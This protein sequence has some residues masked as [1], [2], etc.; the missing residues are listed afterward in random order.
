MYF[1]N[2]T[3]IYEG[4]KVENLFTIIQ[5]HLSKSFQS[6]Q[7]QSFIINLVFSSNPKTKR[8]VST[9]STKSK[10][11]FLSWVFVLVIYSVKRYSNFF[12]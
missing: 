7:Y 3:Q 12:S 1:H 8:S 5:K 4:V 9:K 2:F 10:V 6:D 11:G